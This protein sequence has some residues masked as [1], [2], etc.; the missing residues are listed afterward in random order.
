[1]TALFRISAAMG[2]VLRTTSDPMI[3]QIRLAWWRERLEELELRN[4]EQIGEFFA[5]VFR[6]ARFPWT[7]FGRQP[8]RPEYT[9]QVDDA[10]EIVD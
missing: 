1:M 8:F 10:F 3:A 5:Q 2:D 9:T 6:D 4:W 7:R